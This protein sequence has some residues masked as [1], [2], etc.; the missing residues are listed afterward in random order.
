[1]VFNDLGFSFSKKGGKAVYFI[2]FYHLNL[3]YGALHSYGCTLGG[4]GRLM[5]GKYSL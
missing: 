3:M 4:S 5:H 2:Y 1:M